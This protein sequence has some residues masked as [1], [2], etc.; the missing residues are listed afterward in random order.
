MEGLQKTTNII[1]HFDLKSKVFHYPLLYFNSSFERYW[2]Y[3][4]HLFSRKFKENSKHDVVIS[5]FNSD[6]ERSQRQGSET[7]GIWIHKNYGFGARM[8]RH[9][10]QFYLMTLS[11]LYKLTV[12]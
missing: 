4:W 12:P 7:A 8:S 10:V 9:E 5:L 3:M 6:F 2:T 11:Q 1:L